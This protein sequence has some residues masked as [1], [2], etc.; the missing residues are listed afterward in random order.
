M[1]QSKLGF[2]SGKG[3]KGKLSG[4]TQM[5]KSEAIHYLQQIHGEFSLLDNNILF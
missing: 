2:S 1:D 4:G 5:S 3:S